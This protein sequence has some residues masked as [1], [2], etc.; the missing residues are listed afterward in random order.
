MHFKSILISLLDGKT[1]PEIIWEKSLDTV[2]L[3]S[4]GSKTGTSATRFGLE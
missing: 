2:E 4:T 1:P 3:F